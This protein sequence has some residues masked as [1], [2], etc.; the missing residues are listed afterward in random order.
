MRAVF[1]D[2]GT[3]SSGD[4]DTRTLE[5]ALPG[6]AL[7]DRTPQAGVPAR[8]AGHQVVLANKSVIDGATIAANPQ[9][10]LIA[11]TATGVD[12]V[13][14]PAAR[15]AGVAVCNLRGYC[16]DSVAQHTFA[17]LLAL[18]HRVADYQALVAGGRW[19]AAGQFSVFPYPIREL[20]S[21]VL[22][23]VGHG[24][25]GRAVAGV[26]RASSPGR[27]RWAAVGEAEARPE[28]AAGCPAA[29]PPSCPLPAAAVRAPRA[30][31]S[32][33]R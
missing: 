15:A 11:L 33:P 30:S 14:V 8:I 9:L 1:L 22:G 3:V 6:I 23:I 24:A 17:L 20:S 4:L 28:P 7:H 2:F 18:T 16:T 32:G 29:A 13:D 27:E 19:Q 10:K 5:R 31:G 12:N 21:R 26:A 25:L